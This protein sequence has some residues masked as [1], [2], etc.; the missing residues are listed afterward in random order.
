MVRSY[1]S[2]DYILKAVGLLRVAGFSASDAEYFADLIYPI[3]SKHISAWLN[4]I[5]RGFQ[6]SYLKSALLD[7]HAA[8]YMFVKLDRNPSRVLLMCRQA[9]EVLQEKAFFTERY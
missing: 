3:L 5:P 6:L 8:G 1:L 4:S 2:T 7:V 9:W